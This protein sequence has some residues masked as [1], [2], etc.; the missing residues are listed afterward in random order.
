MNAWSMSSLMIYQH[1]KFQYL[2]AVNSIWNFTYFFM[3]VINLFPM[4]CRIPWM[5][6]KYISAILNSSMQNPYIVKRW[7]TLELCRLKACCPFASE[8]SHAT[9]KIPIKDFQY[10]WF[11]NLLYHFEPNNLTICSIVES[12]SNTWQVNSIFAL[13]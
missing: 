2:F 12:Q 4:T 9:S 5:I 8:Y 13:R 11:L 3:S 7:S 10:W 6:G 1:I